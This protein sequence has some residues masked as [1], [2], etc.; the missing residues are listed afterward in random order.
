M[1][2]KIKELKEAGV[3]GLTCVIGVLIII[4]LLLVRSGIMQVVYH[5]KICYYMTSYAREISETKG[6]QIDHRFLHKEVCPSQMVDTFKIWA[7]TPK[8]LAKNY[9]LYLDGKDAYK[10]FKKQDA[11]KE[12][13]RLIKEKKR[14]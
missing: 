8:S 13:K 11:I 14:V 4:F 5:G 3:L 7:W 9:D 2:K 10:K 1:F 6:K 12:E